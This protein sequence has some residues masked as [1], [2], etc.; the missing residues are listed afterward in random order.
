MTPFGLRF[1]WVAATLFWLFVTILLCA[2]IWWLAQAEALD[3]RRVLIWQ[4]TFYLAWIPI[5]VAIWQAVGRW[6]AEDRGRA[7]VIGTHLIVWLLV[8]ALHTV[9]S[10]SVGSS[11]AV[12]SP[13]GERDRHERRNT[14]TLS[15]IAIRHA[16]HVSTF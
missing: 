4:S 1:Q 10:G 11:R 6:R 5:T 8:G 9:T 13:C 14:M 3:V 16:G 7:V 12:M 15:A 2:Q